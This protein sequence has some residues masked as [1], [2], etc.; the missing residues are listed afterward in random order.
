MT[1]EPERTSA[2]F[3]VLSHRRRRYVLSYFRNADYDA[4]T[5]TVRRY[6]TKL[7]NE[8][9]TKRRVSDLP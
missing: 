3:D 5:E 7:G 6:G 4:R 2:L 9:R 1:F 8:S